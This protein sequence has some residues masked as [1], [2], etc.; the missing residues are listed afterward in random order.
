MGTI[1]GNIGTASPIGDMPPVLLALE[2]RLKLASARGTR[3]LPLEDFFLGYRKTALAPDEVIESIT[4]PQLWPRRECSS[5]TRSA[6]GATRTSPT[7]AA[8]YRLRIKDGRI[9]GRAHRLRRHGRDAQARE[10]CRGGAQKDGFAAADSPRGAPEGLP[11][12]RRLARQRGL[13]PAGRA[14]TCCAG[15]S[16]A[17]PTRSAGRGRGAMKRRGPYRAAPRQRAEARHRPGALY[18]RHR[19]A[20]RHA[21][22]RAGAEPH[23]AGRLLKKLDLSLAASSPGVVAVF[24]RGDIPGHNNIAAAGKEEPLFAEDKVE[25]RRPAAG[26]GRGDTLDAARAAAER[27]RLDI[28][29]TEADPRYRDGASP[30]RP[31]CRRR[32]PS[33]RGDPDAALK[34]APHTLTRRVQR[35]RA[36]A[37]LSRRPDRL[38]PAGRGRRPAGAFL[39]PASDRSA[40]CLRPGAGLRLQPRDHG[41][42]P[43][44]RR[45]RRQGEQR[46][47]GRRRGGAGRR[48]DRQAGETAPAA[49]DRHDRHRQAARLRL[50][51]HGGLRRRRAACWR[52]TRCW[53]PMP[54]GAST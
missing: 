31:M 3:E 17:S 13:S 16:C 18:R 19:R 30:S 27:A 1:G 35:R 2:A 43:P 41:G 29:P 51:L 38:C 39:D 26:H 4:L 24:C 34:S 22:C 20:A 48:Q 49:R 14:R 47:V 33:L 36:G 45:L 32:R 7:V 52:S 40:A 53:R 15:S 37:F 11:A 5:A 12:D 50:S 9:D 6:S 46:L 10:P 44:G 25:Y 21:A 28:E 54:A 8:G 23:R 42:A